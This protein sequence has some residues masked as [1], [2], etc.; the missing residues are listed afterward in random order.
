MAK[1]LTQEEVSKIYKEQGYELI[2]EY[3]DARSLLFVKDKEGYVCSSYLTN[4]TH[5]Q[6]KI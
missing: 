2:S 3:K 1:K 6:Y 4:L 5:T